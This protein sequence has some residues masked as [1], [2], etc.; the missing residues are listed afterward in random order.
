MVKYFTLMTPGA[1]QET[2][3]FRRWFLRE[4]APQVLLHCAGLRRCIVNLRD[5]APPIDNM[6]QL[7]QG[8]GPRRRYQVVTEMWFDSP[9]DFTDRDRLY[10]SP[11]GR[12]I[13]D[14]LRSRVGEAFTYR[15]TEYIEKHAHPTLLGER[16]PGVK[17]ITL[18]G[19]KPGLSD[20]EGRLGWEVHGPLA[21]RTHVGFSRY[22]RNVVEESL[23]AKAPDYRGIAELQFL[24]IDDAVQR[25][26]P[27]P[28]AA[29]IIEFDTARWMVAYEG[30]FFAEY[31]LR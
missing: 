6:P 20:R 2:G 13:E 10:D 11:V 18:C 29:R 1:N 15:V 3:E 26:F 16:S 24:T 9:A 23:T 27:T 7:A 8:G 30:A 12:A 19:W 5:P 22:V 28:A 31:V 17:M 4:H 25:F 21:L 14:S